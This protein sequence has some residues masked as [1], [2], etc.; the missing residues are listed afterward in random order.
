MPKL[1]DRKETRAYESCKTIKEKQKRWI[2]EDVEPFEFVEL[3]FRNWR[4]DD[5]KSEVELNITLCF[6]TLKIRI[7]EN[8]KS[9]YSKSSA[10]CQ[11]LIA[12]FPEDLH[13]P[14]IN[15]HC[16]KVRQRRFLEGAQKSDRNE[17]Y[18][19]WHAYSY[20]MGLMSAAIISI[21]GY[22]PIGFSM[23]LP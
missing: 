14:L 22:F 5:L 4:C 10:I 3:E 2:S 12:S 13:V 18:L 15:L 11:L 20:V 17:K 16:I 9:D 7:F 8:L 21:G 1:N 6:P 19:S 23:A